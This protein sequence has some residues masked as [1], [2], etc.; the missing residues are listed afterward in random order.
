MK[1][2]QR[3]R[4]YRR[5]LDED[6]NTVAYIITIDGTDVEVTED[7]YRSY[8]EMDRR[9]RYQ[10]EAKA[11]QGFM[12]IGQMDDDDV[13]L[14]YVCP[15]LV[16]SCEE[17]VLAAIEAEEREKQLKIVRETLCELSENDRE[18]MTALFVDGVGIREFARQKGV[19]D[20]AI[21]KRR[22]RVLKIIKENLQKAQNQG[23]H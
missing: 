2:W 9:E 14:E 23:T 5:I 16:E 12:S 4:N 20:R 18:L 21:R 3:K 6:G 1:N 10:E 7:V 13:M 11:A 15:D 22:D 17:T 19:F 8:S